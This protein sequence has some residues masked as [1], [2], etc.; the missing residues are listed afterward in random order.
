MHPPFSC[1]W[2]TLWTCSKEFCGYMLAI[3]SILQSCWWYWKMWN[4]PLSYWPTETYSS[5]S[6]ATHGCVANCS[7]RQYHWMHESFLKWKQQ[8]KYSLRTRMN[9][10][11][12][13]VI[14]V[15]TPVLFTQICVR[16][17]YDSMNPSGG[18]TYCNWLKIITNVWNMWQNYLW[19][20]L[21]SVGSL[22]RT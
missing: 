15:V 12:W 4:F 1:I 10:H 14:P 22:H 3:Y 11:E 8:Q 20:I 19:I 17:L 21:L 16:F 5:C 13:A 6:T 7:N 18:Q 9:Q 2:S